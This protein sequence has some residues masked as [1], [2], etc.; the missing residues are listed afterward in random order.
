MKPFE[1][2]RAPHGV[3]HLLAAGF[4]LFHALILWKLLTGSFPSLAVTLLWAVFLVSV[5]LWTAL[6]R[7]LHG[8]FWKKLWRLAILVAGLGVGLTVTD[9]YTLW[10]APHAPHLLSLLFALLA[11]ALAIFWQRHL[12]PRARL[13]QHLH[14]L[15]SGPALALRMRDFQTEAD[16]SQQDERA[17][18]VST[19]SMSG[20]TLILTQLAGQLGLGALTVL[21]G[22]GL[23]PVLRIF[24]REVQDLVWGY[25][26][27]LSQKLRTLGTSWG[28]LAGAGAVALFTLP[29]H[30]VT[31]AVSSTAEQVPNLPATTPPPTP[32]PLPHQ[33]FS[34][35]ALEP[36]QLL[37]FIGVLT[38]LRYFASVAQALLMLFSVLLSLIPLAAVVFLLWPLVEILQGKAQEEPWLFY[39]RRRLSQQLLRFWR[40]LLRRKPTFSNSA[41]WQQKAEARTLAQTWARNGQKRRYSQLAEAF[42]RL[43]YW[44]QKESQG[45]SFAYQPSET[46]HAYLSRLAKSW[47]NFAEPLNLISQAIDQELYAPTPLS[48]HEW[49]RFLANVQSVVDFPREVG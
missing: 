30:G 45:T 21:V 2:F 43:V 39:W 12:T 24:R 49:K 41:P 17:L 26:W 28:L 18:L 44:A 15:S 36:W 40:T 9:P 19:L 13:F 47:P 20:L 14:G 37:L 33:E 27:S 32:S 1:V 16:F 46:T 23:L 22:L 31:L 10:W 34:A 29:E 35:P 8:A 3:H 38:L 25:R 7:Y 4:P 11:G 5:S 6:A 48:S 42:L